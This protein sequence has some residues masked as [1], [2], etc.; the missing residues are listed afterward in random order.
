MASGTRAA[1]E[2]DRRSGRC[3]PAEATSD[4]ET[5]RRGCRQAVWS[6][7][8]HGSLVCRLRRARLAERGS[9]CEIITAARSWSDSALGSHKVLFG[10]RTGTSY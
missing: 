7:N 4:E 6:A 5:C 1:D 9:P 10:Q 3:R 2:M 8:Q